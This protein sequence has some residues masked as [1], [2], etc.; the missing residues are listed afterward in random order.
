MGLGAFLGAIRRRSEGRPGP[1]INQTYVLDQIKGKV[2]TCFTDGT[3]GKTTS[4]VQ[5]CCLGS[6]SLLFSALVVNKFGRVQKRLK[7]GAL[8]SCN[9]NCA[10]ETKNLLR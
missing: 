2:H 9:L 5:V 3:L 8:D 7:V 6:P 1:V 4:G 10:T